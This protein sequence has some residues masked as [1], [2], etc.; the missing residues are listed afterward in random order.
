MARFLFK[1]K[2]SHKSQNYTM[3]FKIKQIF[4]KKKRFETNCA[5]VCIL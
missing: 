3:L 5:V 1:N 2:R 4:L